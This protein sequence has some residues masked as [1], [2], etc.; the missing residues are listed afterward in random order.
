MV[1]E[2]TVIVSIAVGAI[3][4]IVFISLLIARYHKK[5]VER[6][7]N[8]AN[9]FGAQF[10]EGSW[11]EQPRITGVFARRNFELTFHV[12]GAG[13]SNITYLDLIVH[14]KPCDLEFS[15][16]KRTVFNGL[17][18]VFSSSEK[19][20]SGDSYFDKFVHIEGKQDSRL[21]GMVYDSSFKDGAVRLA[22]RGF[23]VTAKNE[24]IIASKI[25]SSKKDLDISTVQGDLTALDTVASAIERC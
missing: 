17:G 4:I 6:L 10:L 22:K 11:K 13:E 18:R 2:T 16:K 7:E 15:F 3:A 14:I 23:T 1:S 25:H 12:V 24:R 20:M 9:S 19:I 8:L 21:V 5:R